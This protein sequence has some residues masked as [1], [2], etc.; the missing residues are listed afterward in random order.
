MG[1]LPWE[2]LVESLLH[3][4]RPREVLS[5]ISWLGLQGLD[6]LLEGPFPEASGELRLKRE[7][8][9]LMGS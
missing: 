1:R 9:H 4:L 3:P 7:A 5:G 8:L 2:L 6:R